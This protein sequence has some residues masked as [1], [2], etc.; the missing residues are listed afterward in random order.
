MAVI[1]KKVYNFASAK[2]KLHQYM[3]QIYKHALLTLL[4]GATCATAGA[5]TGDIINEDF[6]GFTGLYGNNTVIEKNGWTVHGCSTGTNTYTGMIKFELIDKRTGNAYATTPAFS[7]LTETCNAVMTFRYANTNN[8]KH[9]SFSV[10]INRGGR[11]PDGSTTR[12]TTITTKSEVFNSETLKL[13]GVSAATSITIKLTST[14]EG[15]FVLDDVVISTADQVVLSESEPNV[16][17][18]KV[19]DVTVGRTIQ[20][21]VWNTLCLP[22]DIDPNTMA[23]ATGNAVGDVSLRTYTG[24]DDGAMIFTSVTD[25]IS[26]GTPFLVKIATTS[27]NPFFPLASL[28]GDATA[29]TITYGNASMT[30]T[31]APTDIGTTGL[32]LTASGELKKASGGNTTLKG[33]RAYFT[34]ASGAS[35]RLLFSDGTMGISE[36]ETAPTANRW[37]TLDGQELSSQPTQRGIYIKDGKKVIIR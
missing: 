13:I 25:A 9:A 36:T 1:W 27:E 19:A 23:Q 4:L 16:L 29:Q 32:F 8:S 30:G 15:Y 37:Y 17:E 11:F 31:L 28:K 10:T 20:G 2:P 26:A 3:K 22:F 6:S 7:G 14:N 35:A 12:E 24:Y 34:V 21:G 18:T 33:L 5:T